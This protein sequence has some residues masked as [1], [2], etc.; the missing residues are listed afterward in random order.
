MRRDSP[1]KLFVVAALVAITASNALRA[2]KKDDKKE[3]EAQRQE[4][5]ALLT[6]VDAVAAGQPAPTGYPMK[7]EQAHFIKAQSNRTYVPFTVT[8]DPAS[9]SSPAASLY[10]RVVDKNPA[11]TTAPAA[12]ATDKDKDKDKKKDAKNAP[13]EFAFEDV[14][15]I[16]LVKPADS[17]GPLRISRAFSVPAGDYDVYVALKERMPAGQ[18]PDKNAPPPKMGVVKQAVTVPNFWTDELTTSSVILAAKAEPLDAAMTAAQQ[19]ENPYAIGGAKF[20][21]SLDGKFSKKG[22]LNIVFWV[23]NPAVDAA[24]KPDVTIEY[25]F[26]QKTADAEKYFNKTEPQKLNASSLP[27]Q[28]D[29]AAGHQLPGSLTIPLASFPEGEFRLEIKITD[30]ITKKTVTRDVRFSVTT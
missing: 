7:W 29:F 24:K 3:Q 9:I 19:A 15:A 20:T 4:V 14:H 11:A 23:Y 18:K 13:R 28:F 6:A 2:Q 1:T 21:P 17:A 5:Q 12:A 27:P 25:N 10:L 30:N 22:E 26:H 16:D 8:V